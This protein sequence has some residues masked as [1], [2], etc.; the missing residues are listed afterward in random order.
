MRKR[1]TKRQTQREERE[2]NH[3]RLLSTENKLRVEAG[4]TRWVRD[5]LNG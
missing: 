1:E 5:E 4:G 2:V 3:R